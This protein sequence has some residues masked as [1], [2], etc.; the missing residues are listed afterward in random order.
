MP[1]RNTTA[2]GNRAMIAAKRSGK[3]TNGVCQSRIG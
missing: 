3:A 1:S 2:Q